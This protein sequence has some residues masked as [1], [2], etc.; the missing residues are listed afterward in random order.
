[1]SAARAAP[2]PGVSSK[3]TKL[4]AILETA[5]PPS[6]Q[7]YLPPEGWDPRR[8]L[9]AHP[10][11]Y[12]FVQQLVTPT[13]A[14][15][16]WRDVIPDPA[17]NVVLNLGCGTQGL[18]PEMINVDAAAFPHVDVQA[19]LQARLPFAE[20][21][22]DAVVAIAVIE[23]LRDP[24]RLV[25]E[26]SRVLK[27]GGICYLATPF[28]YPFHAAPGDYTRWTQEGLRTL[29]G[30][31][32][33]VVKS[34]ARGG[35]AGVLILVLSHLAAQLLCFGSAGVYTTVN[36]G[37]MVALSPLKLLDVVLGRLPFSAFLCPNLYVVARKR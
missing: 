10:R 31:D 20:R 14:S 25:A 29:L 4:A 6:P 15:E 2:D 35:A 28:V 11:V 18:H 21:S 3:L 24:G 9:L 34:G 32:F 1:V 26:A 23:H 8:V 19:D 36:Y 37:A 16:S 27:P 22:V 30:E 17:A 13:V 12:A 33:E 7:P 5:P